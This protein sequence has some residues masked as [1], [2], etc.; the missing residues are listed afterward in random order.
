MPRTP[1]LLWAAVTL[2]CLVAG[3]APTPTPVRCQSYDVAA[4]TPD[5][6]FAASIDGTGLPLIDQAAEGIEVSLTLIRPISG[7]ITLVHVVAEH[8]AERWE[9]TTPTGGDQPWARCFISPSPTYSTC[10]ASVANPPVA[11][12]GYYYLLAHQN[13]VLEAGLS[14]RLCN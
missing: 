7:P 11:P 12:G 5:N 14:F 6:Q 3:C 2:A 8:E 4:L 13:T 9:L 1:C 10:S